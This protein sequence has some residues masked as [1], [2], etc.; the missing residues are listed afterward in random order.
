MGLSNEVG[1]LRRACRGLCG[2]GGQPE[3]NV[4]TLCD[5]R[6]NAGLNSNG[7]TSASECVAFGQ[8]FA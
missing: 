3:R 2:A 5:D 1:H 8:A 4:D 7:Y 6:V